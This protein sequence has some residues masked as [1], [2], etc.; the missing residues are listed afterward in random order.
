[1]NCIIQTYEKTSTKKGIK[2]LK[3]LQIKYESLYKKVSKIN[4][5]LISGIRENKKQLENLAEDYDILD[6]DELEPTDE[7]LNRLKRK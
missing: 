5:K 4:K 7:E 3:E 2:E 6:L 1:M